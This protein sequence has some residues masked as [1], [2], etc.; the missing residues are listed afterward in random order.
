MRSI[1]CLTALATLCAACGIKGPLY[2]PPPR[3]AAPAAQPAAAT[4]AQAPASAPV[5]S[6]DG[7][8]TLPPLAPVQP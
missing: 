6:G 2:L 8:K 3:P 1:I 4:P 5:S 7:S